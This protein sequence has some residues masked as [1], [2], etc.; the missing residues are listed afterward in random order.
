MNLLVMATQERTELAEFLATLDREEWDAPTLCVG[1]R[2]RDVVAHVISYE[3]LDARGL[4]RRCC[5]KR[6]GSTR[7]R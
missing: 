6:T 3:E 4:A 2:V 1:W 5:W 7:M